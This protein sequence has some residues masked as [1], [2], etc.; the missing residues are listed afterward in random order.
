M[1]IPEIAYY[2][3]EELNTQVKF[4]VSCDHEIKQSEKTSSFICKKINKWGSI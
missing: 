2:K 1:T 4:I 3:F